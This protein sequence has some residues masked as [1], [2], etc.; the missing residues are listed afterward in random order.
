MG[1]SGSG[2]RLSAGDREAV[3]E[4]LLADPCWIR[5]RSERLQSG[6]SLRT[7]EAAF[8]DLELLAGTMGDLLVHSCGLL[9]EKLDRKG[10][11]RFVMRLLDRGYAPHSVSRTLSSLRSFF[12][13]LK[14]RA[15]IAEDPFRLVSGPR[16]TRSLPG[17]LS[18][19][20]ATALVTLSGGSDPPGE[21]EIRDRAILELFYLTGMR[22]SELAA[23]VWGDLDGEAGSIRVLGK[24][25]KVRRVPLVGEARTALLTYREL[26]S[27]ASRSG[28]GGPSSDAPLF[29][30]PTRTPLSVH[31]IGRVVRK[32]AALAGLARTVTPHA[33]RHSCATHLLNRDADLREIQAL[34]GH[35]SLGSTQKYL[36][37]GFA[38]LSKKLDRIREPDSPTGHPSIP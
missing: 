3:R 27:D 4:I 10:A 13:F 5:F 22:L 35:A 8:L 2:H 7:A 6:R 20:E 21:P 24:G 12:G 16:R 11:T 9:W 38:E 34:L 36:H 15:L 31:Q 25:G 28:Q 29:S 30:G 32:R 23:L 19:E 14:A 37:T 17:F 1:G 18:E 33:L 26:R